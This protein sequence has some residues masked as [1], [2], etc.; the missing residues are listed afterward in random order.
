MSTQAYFPVFHPRFWVAYGV[1]MRPYLLFVSGAAGASGM[2]MA[3]PETWPLWKLGLAFLPFFLG[4]GFG[5]ALT[6]CFQVDTDKLSSPYRPLSQGIV[7]VRAVLYCSIVGLM[8]CGLILWSFH[9]FSFLLSLL[10]VA[11]LATYSHIKKKYWYGGPLHNAWIVTLL[12][13]MG[14]FAASELNVRSFPG[15]AYRLLGLTFFSYANFV[16]IGYLK[17]IEADRATHYRT[18]PVVFGWRKTVL[19]GDAWGLLVLY[20]YWVQPP[21]HLYAIVA[22]VLASLVCISGQVYAHLS[23]QEDEKAALFPIVSTVRAFILFNLA[24]CL[25]FQPH[26]L[27]AAVIYYVWF[28]IFLYR[29]PSKYQV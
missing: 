24:I 14:Y 27:L 6:D 19:L 22:G 16:L 21:Q 1:H 15:E 17:D 8:G 28:E 2:A 13:I 29:R 26:W 3:Q 25:Q 23:K 12:P 18:F 11:G 5:Q 20:L 7:S 4:Y 10:A 9:P